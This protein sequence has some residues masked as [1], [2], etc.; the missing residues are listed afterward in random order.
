M[1]FKRKITLRREKLVRFCQFSTG[2]NEENLK[3]GI[4][5]SSRQYGKQAL[6]EIIKE[7]RICDKRPCYDLYKHRQNQKLTLLHHLYFHVFLYCSRYDGLHHGASYL[8]HLHLLSMLKSEGRAAPVVSLTD[9]LLS[10]AIGVAAQLSIE[11]G[12]FIA[13][14][15]VLQE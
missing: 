1:H 10:V 12:R 15:E 14:Q 9:G 3:T 7:I 6:N 8:E 13:I 4:L 5:H 2:L 11:K